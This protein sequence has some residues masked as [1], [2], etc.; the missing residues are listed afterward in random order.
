VATRPATLLAAATLASLPFESTSLAFPL[1]PLTVTLPEALLGLTVAVTALAAWEERRGSIAALLVDRRF[2]AAAAVFLGVL[3]VSAALAVEQQPNAVRF[4]LRLAG[5]AAFGWAVAWLVRAEPGRARLL[6]GAYAG[7][8]VAAAAIG[9]LEVG[10]GARLDPVLARFRDHPVYVA[11]VRRLTGTYAYA[12]IAATS[13]ALALPVLAA[14]SLR[15]T[16][17]AVAAVVPALMLTYSRGGLVAALLGLLALVWLGGPGP[18]ARAAGAVIALAVAWVVL[19][20]FD[21]LL[22]RRTAGEGDGALLAARVEAPSARLL[23]TAGTRGLMRVKV[24]NAGS[25]P[26]ESSGEAPYRLTSVWY[27][28]RGRRLHVPTPRTDL[29]ARVTPGQTVTVEGR[30]IVPEYRGAAWLVWDV[31][32]ERRLY[33]GEYG[34]AP[35]WVPAVVG[36]DEAEARRLDAALPSIARPA[37]VRAWIPPARG[38]LWSAALAMARERPWLGHGPDSYR[39]VYGR[40]LGLSWW[41]S[42][43]YANN[44]GLELLAT[45]GALGLAAFLGVLGAVGLAALAGLRTGPPESRPWIAVGLS[46]LVAFLAHGVVDYFLEFT[47]GYVP[48]WAA[49]GLVVGLAARDGSSA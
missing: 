8:V 28:E 30:Y 9:L 44:L 7:G 6:L 34:S 37:R 35:G 27:D 12:N 39:W 32:I 1:G 48:F 5:G 45:T 49:V 26:W 3:L 38:R 24:T 11:G 13:V 36:R 40:Y 25:L 42:R 46:M 20:Q 29:P 19:A 22:P 17:V 10:L 47:A 41:D 14:W 2:A 31:L 43:V 21:A 16:L 4:T 23:A 15:A 18:R 33:L